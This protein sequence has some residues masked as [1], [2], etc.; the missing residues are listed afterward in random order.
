MHEESKP[1]W[2]A[3]ESKKG[4]SVKFTR[5]KLS[6]FLKL[7]GWGYYKSHKSR[8]AKNELTHP[9]RNW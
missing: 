5:L 9:V 8:T 1:F 4:F 3:E 7:N 6:R 2:Y